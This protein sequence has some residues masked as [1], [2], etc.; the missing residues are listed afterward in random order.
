MS[1]A[2]ISALTSATTPL[3][4]TEALPIVQGGTTKQV[5]IANLTIGRTQTT[6]G[7]VQGAAATG[8]NFSAN[9]SASG[10]TSQLLNWYEEGT[11]TPNNFGSLVVV[12]TFSS[13]GRYT[14]IGR[15]VMISGY[16][17]GTT[18][19]AIGASGIVSS[20]LPYSA[21]VDSAGNMVNVT[22]NDSGVIRI[23]GPYVVAATTIAATPTITF[24]AIYTV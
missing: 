24:S 1:N 2:K 20:N 8:Y 5:S 18:S 19:V 15:L 10:M 16:V 11:W 14:R 17:S 4:G 22:N 13:G 12:G 21:A 3:A 23:A 9:T 7:L 6:N